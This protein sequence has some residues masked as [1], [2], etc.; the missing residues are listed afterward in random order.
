MDGS[1]LLGRTLA[2]RGAWLCAGSHDC[3]ELAVKRRAFERALRAA[4]GD[5]A[6]TTLRKDFVRQFPAARG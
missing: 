6:L 3:L 1:L 4:V 2:G 5:A